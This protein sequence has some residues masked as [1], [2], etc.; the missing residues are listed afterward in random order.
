MA[1]EPLRIVS[2][3]SLQR[4]PRRARLDLFARHVEFDVAVEPI[5]RF[6]RERRDQYALAKPPIPGVD[7]E[8]MDA[9]VGVVDHEVLDMADFAVDCVKAV[10]RHFVDAAQVRIGS[11]QTRALG[12][13]LVGAQAQAEIGRRHIGPSHRAGRLA[14]IGAAP[15]RVPAIVRIELVLH[16][17]RHRLVVS[18]FLALLDLGLRQ[19]HDKS[20]L[21]QVGPRNRR[22]MDQRLAPGQPGA[23]IDDEPAHFP[24]RVVEQEIGDGSDQAVFRLDRETSQGGNDL[25]HSLAPFTNGSCRQPGR[26]PNRSC[27]F[28]V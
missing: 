10:S 23:A 28:Q 21:F 20:L 25:H 12:M 26:G 17:L 6:H 19:R 5:D 22:G 11:V 18:Q 1:V 3:E 14:E 2:I 27:R 13:A 15:E 9:P 24:C 16:L 8:I 7:D 4:I